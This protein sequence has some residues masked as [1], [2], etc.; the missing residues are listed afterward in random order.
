MA[1]MSTPSAYTDA[2]LLALWRAAFAEVS[3]GKAYSINGRSFT[4]A[5]SKEIRDNIDWLEK[6]TSGTGTG[7]NIAYARMNRQV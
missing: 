3:K 6:R 4:K 7:N 1:K 5:D 2:E